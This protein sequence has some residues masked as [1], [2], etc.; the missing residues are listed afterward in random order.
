LKAGV[1]LQGESIG[2]VNI[3]AKESIEKTTIARYETSIMRSLMM[4]VSGWA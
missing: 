1:L 2:S 3:I 4:N